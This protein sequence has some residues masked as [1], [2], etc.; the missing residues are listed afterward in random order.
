MVTPSPSALSAASPRRQHQL[1][2]SAPGTLQRAFDALADLP[3][4]VLLTTGG[5]S[6][7]EALIAPANAVVRGFVPHVAVLPHVALAITHAG[8]GTV[9]AALPHVVPLVC[10]PSLGAD[11]PIIAARVEAL[12][13]GKSIKPG[14][15]ADEIRSAVLHVLREPAYQA[16]AQRLAELIGREDGAARGAAELRHASISTPPT[17]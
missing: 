13:A 17:Q 4:R 12:G 11:Q 7:P 3:L 15:S 14:A 5:A 16:S 2:Q 10:Q 6:A 9:M 1:W 8:R